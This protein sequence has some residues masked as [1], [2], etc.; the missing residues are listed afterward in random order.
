MRLGTEQ[1]FFKA[2]SCINPILPIRIWSWLS[3]VFFGAFELTL[4]I[5]FRIYPPRSALD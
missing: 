3:E 5:P 1:E 4:T 2:R